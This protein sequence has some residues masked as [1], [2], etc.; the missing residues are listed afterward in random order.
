MPQSVSEE[1]DIRWM[2][3]ALELAERSVGLSSPN[4]AVGC[5]LTREGEIA[6]EGFHQYA[7]LDHAEIVAL[8]QAGERARGSTAYVT[9]EPCSHQG[10]TGP[11]ADAL[12][13]AGVS[14]VVIATRDPNPKVHG[15]GIAKLLAGG[16][17]VRTGIGQLPARRLNDGFARFVVSGLPFVTLKVA[18]SLDG[19]IAAA[20]GS[21][22]WITS[23]AARDEVHTMRHAA[24]ALLTGIGTVLADDPRLTDRSGLPRR[25][26]LLRVVLD[27]HLR[28][29]LDSQLV[30]TAEDDL[31]IFF[32]HG[33]AATEK[34]L[35]E[36]GIRTHRVTGEPAEAGAAQARIPLREVM[37]ALAKLTITNLLVEGGSEINAAML[38]EK[39]ADRMVLFYAPMVLGA[40]AVPMLAPGTGATLP[41]LQSQSL[42]EFGP[43]FAFDGYL[44]DPW[45]GVV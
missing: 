27:S 25:R 8:K 10:R 2:R 15:Q 41:P 19:R 18:S 21:R 26:P 3:R 20:G 40:E 33:S 12:L 31:L 32:T 24:D 35:R 30:T 44:R 5:V 23:E 1:E 38:K 42:R 37:E 29:P 22:S 36:R 9:L 4:P 45:V 43:D 7:L 16:V 14:S 28:T 34:A 17:T 13:A 11:C 39:A 6:G